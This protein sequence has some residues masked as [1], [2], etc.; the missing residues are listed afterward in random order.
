MEFEKDKVLEMYV[1]INLF[2]ICSCWSIYPVFV[3]KDG[4]MICQSI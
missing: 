3:I 1:G 2:F 4:Q